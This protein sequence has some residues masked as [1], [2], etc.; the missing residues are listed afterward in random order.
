[1]ELK[2]RILNN[3]ENFENIDKGEIKKDFDEFIELL[4][5]GKIR[6]A[7][8]KDNKWIANEW[9]KKGILLGFKLGNVVDYSIEGFNFYDKDTYPAKT[10][11]DNKR[12]IVPGGTS[13][14]KGSYLNENVIVM[15]P[16]YVNVGAYV[17]SDTLL[18]SNVLV[19]SCAQVGSNC[20]ISAGVQ[21]GGVLEPINSTP[22]IVEDNVFIGGNSGIYEGVLIKKGA[23]ISSGV[24]ITASTPIYDIVNEEIIKKDNDGVLMIP[25][26]AV[27]VPGTR[28]INT[29]FGKNQ[30]LSIST[31]IIIKYKDESTSA[32]LSLEEAL[33]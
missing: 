20:H 23:V 3:F 11:N 9:V 19:G 27:V 4:D 18:D 21:I 30:N 16:T 17:D 7:I 26:N 25:E 33:R 31:P 1:M 12:R 24:V 28:P 10:F 13:L 5:N 14:R 2:N 15:P 8:K 32:K 22:V 6:S 29:D